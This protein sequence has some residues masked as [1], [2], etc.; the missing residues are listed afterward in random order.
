MKHKAK[1][2]EFAFDAP[3]DFRLIQDTATDWDR[4][5]S[6]REQAEKSFAATSRAQE[7]DARCP[8]RNGSAAIRA[9]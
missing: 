9:S 2:T 5:Q 3:L 4:V 8:G 1:P 6:E 7:T